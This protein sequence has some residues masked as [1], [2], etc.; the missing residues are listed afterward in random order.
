MLLSGQ[1]SLKPS[2]KKAGETMA[3]FTQ[4][5]ILQAKEIDLLTYLQNYEPGNLVH[6][7][8]NTYCTREHDSLK[9]SNGKWCWF[10]R[11]IGGKTALDYLI[12]V[13]GYSFI[14]SME[15]LT[16]K[17]A[18]APPVFKKAPVLEDRKL[19]LPDQNENNDRVK[20][21]LKGRGIHDVIIDHCIAGGML[22]ESKDYHNCVFLGFDKNGTP[23]YGNI[24][25]TNGP[26][27]GEVSGSNKHFSFCIPGKS[28]VIH[29]F[30]AAIDAMSYATLQLIEGKDWQNDTLLSLAGV[31]KTKRE[32]VVPVAL[33]QY[34]EDHPGVTAIRLHLDNDEVGRG[35][36]EGIITGLKGRYHVL[37]EP[38]RFGKDVNDYL[39]KRVGL[40]QSE[41]L[42][43]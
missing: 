11:G 21:Y 33:Q 37:D 7:G 34:L 1:I 20:Q 14:Q 42:S 40:L 29:V 25:S 30:E 9:I 16:G 24:R 3:I 10:S 8:G 15:M 38:P 28:G 35:A 22:Y 41:K 2:V 26:Y 32:G 23:R 43:R 13:K 6:V 36:V 18:T 31:F 27:K 4:E 12:K 39:R 17:V 5:E 19:L